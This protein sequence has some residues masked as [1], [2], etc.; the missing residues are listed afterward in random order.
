[1]DIKLHP[2]NAT[3]FWDVQKLVQGDTFNTNLCNVTESQCRRQECKPVKHLFYDNIYTGA[4]H[5]KCNSLS[6]YNYYINKHL[7]DYLSITSHILGVDICSEKIN[8]A[9]N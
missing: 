6:S 9:W 3:W 5:N 2:K 8:P 1:M 7:L 4:C